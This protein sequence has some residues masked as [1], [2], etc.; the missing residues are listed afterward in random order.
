MALPAGPEAVECAR[1][2]RLCLLVTATMGTSREVV[3]G[4]H[5]ECPAPAPLQPPPRGGV[6]SWESWEKGQ[7]GIGSIS[8]VGCARSSWQCPRGPNPDVKKQQGGRASSQ[9]GPVATALFSIPRVSKGCWKRRKTIGKVE[10]P[11]QSPCAAP[12]NGDR[13]VP[14]LSVVAQTDI[15]GLAAG[16]SAPCSCFWQIPSAWPSRRCRIP[17]AL[18]SLQWP[19]NKCPSRCWAR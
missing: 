9:A 17:P 3:A 14:S 2:M 10:T 1:G 7:V 4:G 16:A 8:E 6:T 19:S 5:R 13:G 15:P 11:V 12:E 18:A